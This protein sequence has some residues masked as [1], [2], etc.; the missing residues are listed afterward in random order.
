MAGWKPDRTETVRSA[1]GQPDSRIFLWIVPAQARGVWV[2]GDL[3]VKVSQNFQEID[4]EVERGRRPV[5][6][7]RANLSGRDISWETRDMRFNGRVEGPRT[8]GELILDGRTTALM[9]ERD[10]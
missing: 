10:R 7:T 8:V 1:Q 2:G 9:L 6:V 4:V 5:A 3:R